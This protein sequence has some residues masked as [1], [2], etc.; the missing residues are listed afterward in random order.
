MHPRDRRKRR[1]R[2]HWHLKKETRVSARSSPIFKRAKVPR[3]LNERSWWQLSEENKRKRGG[4]SKN[5]QG[6]F[7]LYI[8]KYTWT[9]F[10]VTSIP[11]IACTVVRANCVV[12]KRV[13]VT[14]GGE[15]SAFINICKNNN[16][17]DNTDYNMLLYNIKMK[18]RATRKKLKMGW[19][20]GWNSRSS[21]KRKMKK[22]K[23]RW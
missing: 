10:P 18:V 16:D 20:L 23:K 8:I 5:N 15:S 14:Y 6:E 13:H 7:R 21:D 17:N 22:R 19:R 11:G 3:H 1:Q 2:I 9:G 4:G 12:T